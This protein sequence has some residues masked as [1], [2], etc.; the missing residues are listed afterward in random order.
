MTISPILLSTPEAQAMDW[1]KRSEG[2]WHSQRRYYTLNPKVETQE[3]VS[4]ITVQ[5]LDRG[6]PQLI[7]LAHL[8]GLEEADAFVGGS[9]VTWE[10]DYTGKIRKPS[11]GSTILGIKENLLYR[12]RGFATAKPVTATYHLS[13]KQTLSLRT[14][15]QGSVFEEELKLIGT[16]Y[17]TRQTIISRAGQEV[18][19][20][21]Y[22]ETRVD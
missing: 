17:R 21:Q 7:E 10:S 15:Y 5:V 16:H 6:A 8:H 11:T 19:I 12:D 13:N 1:F 20:G 3:V 14:E 2:M 18:M 9:Y 4:L 22:L